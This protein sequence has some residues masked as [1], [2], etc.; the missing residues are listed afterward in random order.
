MLTEVEPGLTFQSVHSATRCSCQ[1]GLSALTPT[2]AQSATQ[3]GVNHMSPSGAGKPCRVSTQR[4]IWRECTLN[5]THIHTFGGRAGPA[6]FCSS[7]FLLSPPPPPSPPL[8]CAIAFLWFIYEMCMSLYSNGLDLVG[9]KMPGMTNSGDSRWSIPDL[10]SVSPTATLCAIWTL[11]RDKSLLFVYP[12]YD[13][14]PSCSR[15]QWDTIHSAAAECKK[16]LLWFI[17][18]TPLKPPIIFF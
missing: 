6:V 12:G 17:R 2:R 9:K 13:S 11:T 4:L 8:S 15:S 3:L 5:I 16:R 18:L 7:S 10:S 14:I 1:S